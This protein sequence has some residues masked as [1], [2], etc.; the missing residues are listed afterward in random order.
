MKSV[1][2]VFLAASLVLGG[3]MLVGP[4][5]S[6]EV[7]PRASALTPHAPI[8]INNNTDFLTVAGVANNATGNGTV[9]NPWVIENL[10]INGT[11]FGY[12]IYIGNTTDYFTIRN[13][14][15]HG[16]SGVGTWSYYSDSGIT[17]LYVYN[18]ILE[19]N[20]IYSNGQ[21]GIYLKYSDSNTL[22]NNTAYGNG[23]GIMLRDCDDNK[24]LHNNASD[25]THHGFDI[26]GNSANNWYFNNTASNNTYNGFQLMCVENL[27]ENNTIW[28]NGWFG[29]ELQNSES[30]I[31]R[32]NSLYGNGIRLS[33]A[34][35]S[36]WNTFSID[37]SNTVNGKPVI[38]MKNETGGS[39]PA[40]AGQV[41]LANCT[42]VDVE[43]IT[44]DNCSEAVI[45]GFSDSNNINNV[46][47][48][49]NS[50]WGMYLMFSNY[51]NI[52]N[53]AFYGND[54]SMSLFE[55]GYNMV[56]NNTFMASNTGISLGMAENNTL[57]NNTLLDN[58]FGISISWASNN[59]VY[60][61]SFYNNGDS[62][63]DNGMNIWDDGYPSGG[64]YW[65][66]YSGVDYYSGADQ[67]AWG[68]DGI[69]DSPYPIPSGS[70]TDRYPLMHPYYEL[71][72]DEFVPPFALSSTPNG[73]AVPVDVPIVI[74]WNETMDWASVAAA[75]SYTDGTTE[76]TSANGTWVHN[77]TT[78][79]S[80]FTPAE[81][82][83]YETH[84][85]VT[86][87]SSASDIIGNMLDQN[88]NGTGGELDDFL[89]WG[90][91]TT[92]EAPFVVSTLPA[93][94]Q[95]DVDPFKPIKIVFSERMNK[96]A[97]Q[98]AFSYTDGNL[99]WNITSGAAYWNTPQTEFTFSPA[100]PLEVNTTFVVTLNGTLAKDVGGKGLNTGDY[101][102]AFTT[103][104]EPP[105][106]QVESTYPP[107]GSFGV[108]VNTYINIVFDSEMDTMSVEEAFSYTNGA[109]VWTVADGAVDWFSDN[110][111]FSFQP[112]EKLDFDTE[113]TV[114]L[115][116]NATSVYGV[117]L[118]GNG[119]GVPDPDDN[120]SF[121]FSTT[122]EP[123]IVES[124]YPSPMEMGVPTSLS[125][126]YINFSKPMNMATVTNALS[127]SPNTPI[128]TT[129]S[130][131]GRNLTITM[132]TFLLEGTEY[133][134][135][136]LGTAMDLGGTRLDGNGDGW[137]GDKF[138]FSFY[139]EGVDAPVTPTIVSIFP[140]NN[141]T[142]PVDAFFVMV[143][144]NSAM[145]RTSVENAFGF[146][147]AT[148]EVNGTFA[149]SNT[150]KSFRFTPSEQ[151]AY[152]TTYTV[153]VAGTAKSEDGLSMGNSTTW[154][155]FT[156]AEVANKSLW[157]W[158]IYGAIICLIA[159]STMLYMANRSLR[160]ELKRTRVKL[161]RLKKQTGIVDDEPAKPAGKGEAGGAAPEEA[162]PAEEVPDDIEKD[163]PS[164]DN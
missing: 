49:N 133:R 54:N 46:T 83:L 82:F 136:V 52:S 70:N 79:I 59:K 63:Y 60:H 98:M 9:W 99:T 24:V 112:V 2:S 117:N 12:C 151:L 159:L 128:T 30:H 140:A 161:K 137:P 126:I 122:L 28:G 106:P 23:Q 143:T 129:F 91:T 74:T 154:Q 68:R 65:D 160:R 114:K 92:D 36:N 120:Y 18:A 134:V 62:A 29:L 155:Y 116:L 1:L 150:G 135:T 38:Y 32:N 90:F 85:V 56:K 10:E 95:I 156:E 35:V 121:I 80:T 110:T 130:G 101:V 17:L 81:A 50:V 142:I 119:N 77:S 153:T 20:T 42:N 107:D 57:M 144:F 157:E 8:R 47:A 76:W 109:D 163:V 78:N 75:F 96:T 127:I 11:G 93:H 3:V 33:G 141:A 131:G 72:N 21:G 44:L 19:N 87:N 145:N 39:V 45:L 146:R 164:E 67:D 88:L 125:A 14:S 61:N 108:N 97:V 41:I 71:A 89:Q 34:W 48:N 22:I 124:H 5:E 104:R 26:S 15:I 53:C 73:T 4:A 27:I 147:N 123:P 115:S 162:A 25:N 105:A 37:I 158:V 100:A 113:Y 102:W 103:W 43:N 51:N 64:N 118:D 13:C 86:V 6:G 139:T 152:N 66:D 84:Y 69:G 16:A 138:T 148:G 7:M 132:N 111:M 149:W 94:G 55:S 31:L 58:S 40:N